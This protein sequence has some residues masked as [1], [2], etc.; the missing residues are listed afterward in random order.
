[1]RSAECVDRTASGE[2]HV[3]GAE[4][5]GYGGDDEDV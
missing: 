3:K 4:G 2:A 1:M 5:G